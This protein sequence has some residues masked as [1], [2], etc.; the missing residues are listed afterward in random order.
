L[1]K[2]LVSTIIFLTQN[3]FW[4]VF[5]FENQTPPFPTQNAFVLFIREPLLS[6]WL[7]SIPLPSRLAT[8]HGTVGKSI[9]SFVSNLKNA[10][11]RFQIPTWE[12]VFQPR[13]TYFGFCCKCLAVIHQ[14]QTLAY[15]SSLEPLNFPSDFSGANFLHQPETNTGVEIAVKFKIRSITEK[16]TTA[17]KLNR[18][19]R[20]PAG[21]YFNL[22]THLPNFHLKRKTSGDSM[23]RSFEFACLRF[24]ISIINGIAGPARLPRRFLPE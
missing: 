15:H 23:R 16:N 18:D 7:I 12:N 17:C 19:F 20:A 9:L 2:Q 13:Q 5:R 11:A 21:W 6:A 4:D 10:S 1:E 22:K 8:N 14:P 3:Q 24:K